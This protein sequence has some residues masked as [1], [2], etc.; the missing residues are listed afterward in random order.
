MSRATTQRRAI[1]EALA[2]ASG[3]L[4][5]E[6]LL[7]RA[8]ERCDSLGQATVYRELK[9]LEQEQRVARVHTGDGR[10]RYEV[11]QAHHHHFHCRACDGVFDLPG[12]VRTPRSLYR[13]LP[14][15]F[16]VEDHEVVL[17]GLCANCT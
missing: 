16:R 13:N 17:R 2:E 7:A 9:R 6:D 11:A 15:G 1:W 14:V 12:C 8:Q 10:V 5:P 3:P 4:V